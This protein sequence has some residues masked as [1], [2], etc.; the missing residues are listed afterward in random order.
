MVLMSRVIAKI[1]QLLVCGERKPKSGIVHA[2]SG[3]D[4]TNGKEGRWRGRG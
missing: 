4:F 2:R 3:V 1:Q